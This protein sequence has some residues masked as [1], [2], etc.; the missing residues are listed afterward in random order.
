MTSFRRQNLLKSQLVVSLIATWCCAISKTSA[1]ILLGTGDPAANT[2]P[3]TGDLAGSGW[4][5]E[6]T[7]GPFLGTTIAPN[8]FITAK[9]VAGSDST[10]YFN[11]TAYPLVRQYNDAFS[12][13][14]IFQVTGT[15]PIVAPLYS[16]GAE[17]GQ[18][19]VAIGRG[20]QRGSE[21][22]LGGTL[23]GWNW[24][25][26]DSVQRWGENYVSAIVHDGPANA[27]VYA[28]FDSTGSP[29]ESHLSSGDSG[30]ALFIQEA[31]VWKLAAINYAVDVLYMDV[32]GNGQF[33][34]A[35]FDARGFYTQD[36]AN[37]PHYTLITGASPQPTGFYSTQISSKLAW[38]YSV[39]APAGDVNGNGISNHLDYA[40]DLNSPAPAGPGAPPV[41]IEGGF[42]T[43][44]Y[45][46]LTTINNLLYTIKKS[47][48]LVNWMPVTPD[49]TV[50][51]SGDDIQTIKAKVPIAGPRMFL[52]LE[53]LEAVQ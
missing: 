42:L 34:A 44:T 25:P 41:T 13:L 31:G 15:F 10:F 3:P 53:I 29:N 39:I 14:T 50:L 20:T 40:R 6:G 24:G 49:E 47:A 16:S 2:T 43:L 36:S 38:I 21:I 32:A 45:R 23:R 37:P 8:F 35:V 7:F 19:L 22:F 18:R 30:G 5:F 46:K 12:D 9:H 27:Y 1:V 4:Q 17:T 33:V 51:T 11:G 48:D 26:G 28:T 52:R